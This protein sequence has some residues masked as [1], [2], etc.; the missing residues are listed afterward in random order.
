[1][2]L[3]SKPMNYKEIQNMTKQK[4]ENHDF[5]PG[6]I[7]SEMLSYWEVIVKIESDILTVIKRK[8]GKYE[9]QKFTPD[10][11]VK[12]CE[13]SSSHP[14]YWIDFIKN[15]REVVNSYIDAYIYQEG[16]TLDKSRDFK[17]DLLL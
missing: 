16:M 2:N 5:K 4:F 6:D 15:D 3:L 11:Y 13:Y 7:F 17:L 10:E 9:L 12:H 14:G 8:G 1:M